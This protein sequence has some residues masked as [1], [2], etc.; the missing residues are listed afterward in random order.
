VLALLDE[1]ANSWWRRRH[2]IQIPDRRSRNRAE[3]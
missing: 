3:P 2:A 1:H